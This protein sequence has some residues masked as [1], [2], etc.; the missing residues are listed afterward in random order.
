MLKIVVVL[1]TVSLTLLSHSNVFA[2]DSST[3]NQEEINKLKAL[4]A[5][6]QK[7]I[8]KLE[9]TVDDQRKLL[10]QAL[11]IPAQ[12]PLNEDQTIPRSRDVRDG[13]SEEPPPV[14]PT[15]KTSADESAPLSIRI[16][17]V[18]VTPYGFVDLT[19]IYR[20]KDVASG[21]ST[22]FANIPFSNTIT[23]QLSELRFTAQN[24]R[25]GARFDTHRFGAD[26]LGLIETD[27]AGFAPGISRL[28][29]TAT[30]R[31]SAWAGSI[32]VRASGNFLADNRGVSSHPT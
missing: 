2:Q 13:T 23:G 32:F 16:G 8:D 30:V 18:S 15:R 26:F 4:V 11:H 29:P 3:P 24:T 12:I 21:I 25:L 27:F 17:K 14:S 28:Q 22:N 10:E 31:A 19:T 20:D 6:Q 5:D 9:R 7:R 1:I